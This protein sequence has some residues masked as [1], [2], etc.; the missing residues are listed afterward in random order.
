MPDIRSF[1]D[2]RGGQSKGLSQEKRVAKETS[3]TIKA[4]ARA[5]RKVLTDSEDD[6]ED[7]G[8]KKSTPKKSVPNKKM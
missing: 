5:K 8:V 4:K 2:G 6:A 1:F 3:K 7:Q